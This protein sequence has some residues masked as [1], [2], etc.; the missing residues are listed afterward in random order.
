MLFP[1]FSLTVK[2]RTSL[3]QTY[4]SPQERTPQVQ[5]TPRLIHEKASNCELNRNYMS[6]KDLSTPLIIHSKDFAGFDWFKGPG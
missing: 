4:Y 2:S 6:Y 1:V 3:G 5:Q